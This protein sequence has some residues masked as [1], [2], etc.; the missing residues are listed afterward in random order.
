MPAEYA[1]AWRLPDAMP[2]NT[3][4][5]VTARDHFVI[6]HTREELC[7]RLAEFRDLTIP[8]EEIRRRYFT[9][10]RSA[11]YAPGDTRKIGR[12]HV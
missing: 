6:A 2:V 11:K 4:A 8:D 9:R 1:S 3:T 7:R 5:P 10:T 12:A